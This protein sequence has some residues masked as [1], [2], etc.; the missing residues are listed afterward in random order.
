MDTSIKF[1]L[2]GDKEL[3]RALDKLI[4][5]ATSP[6]PLYQEIG[7]NLLASTRARYLDET[8]ASGKKWAPL[9]PS[10]LSSKKKRG[11]AYPTE[12][13]LLTGKMFSSL[14]FNA[15]FSGLEL[16]FS[17]EIHYAKW[18]QTGTP[19]MPARPPLGFSDGDKSMIINEINEFLNRSIR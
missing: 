9:S 6:Q 18:H 17:D 11:S 16:G 10:Y 5:S 14:G 8:D 7:E 12:K 3:L 1:N 19:K 15:T 4:Q 2:S 13:L